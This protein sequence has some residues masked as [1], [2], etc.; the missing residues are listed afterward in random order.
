M[1]NTLRLLSI[2]LLT[3]ATTHSSFAGVR[4]QAI[5]KTA[6]V[7]M[8]KFGKGAAGETIE[9]ISK[10]TAKA[11]AKHG[12]GC[13]PLLRKTGHAGFEILEK[14]GKQSKKIIKL[15]A[16]KGDDAIWII[17]KPHRL[18][19]FLKHGD[20]AAEALLKHPNLAEDLI[21]AF[22]KSGVRAAN[23]VSRENGQRL[24][25][26]AADGTLNAIGRKPE[27]IAVIGKHGDAAMNFIWKHKGALTVSSALGLFLAKP[28]AYI[29]GTKSLFVDPIVKPVIQS[30]NWTLIVSAVLGVIFF[31]FILKTL[32]KGY[33]IIKPSRKQKN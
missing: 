7:I 14:T 27:L 2:I 11:V 17:S 13:L 31:P 28:E 25:I 3:V 16:R 10:K 15:H 26:M 24:G 29:N 1:K 12:D 30:V 9:Q 23:A 6:T 33:V 20:D 21:S 18:S 32:K 8:K 19:L 5:K 22:G 4:S